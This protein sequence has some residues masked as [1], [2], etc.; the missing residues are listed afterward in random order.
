M[1]EE[2]LSLC[3][4]AFVKVECEMIMNETTNYYVCLNCGQACDVEV[5]K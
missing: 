2:I 3:C 4:K 1:S 5:R